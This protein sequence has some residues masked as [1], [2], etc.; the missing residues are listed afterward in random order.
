MIEM[1]GVHSLLVS[2]ISMLKASNEEQLSD[3]EN[4]IMSLESS[5]KDLQTELVEL[6]QET[7]SVRNAVGVG[8]TQAQEQMV[9]GICGFKQGVCDFIWAC[10]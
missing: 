6:K 8:L 7:Q 1:R 2:D 3:L 4:T 5:T 10:K 9:R